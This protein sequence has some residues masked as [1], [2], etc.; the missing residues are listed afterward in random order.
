VAALLE[1]MG[2]SLQLNK[3]EKEGKSVPS[4]QIQPI[5]LTSSNQGGI[6]S[7]FGGFPDVWT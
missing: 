6:I 5:C 4:I 3:K 1:E 7:L 2:Y